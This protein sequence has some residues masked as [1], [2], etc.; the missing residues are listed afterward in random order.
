MYGQLHCLLLPPCAGS[1]QGWPHGMTTFNHWIVKGAGLLAFTILAQLSCTDQKS[2][3]D[4]SHDYTELC[5]GF[6]SRYFECLTDLIPPAGDYNT[7]SQCVE[8]CAG[9][10]ML[11][12]CVDENVAVFE[13][14]LAPENACPRFRDIWEDPED[15]PCHS[16]IELRST[17]YEDSRE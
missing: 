11:Q 2:P 13:C 14:Q 15:G 3:S 5:E 17:C 9:N 10:T 6:C 16:E 12:R 7:Q 8:D 1:S 4:D